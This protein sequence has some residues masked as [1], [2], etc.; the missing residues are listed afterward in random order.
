MRKKKWIQKSVALLMVS[1]MIASVGCGKSGEEDKAQKKEE[2][3]TED[4]KDI[5]TIG[6]RQDSTVLDFDTN[7][8]TEQLEKAAN[9]EL[10]FFFFPADANEFKQKLS[11][12]IS[13]E[14]ELP[15]VI[16]TD[17]MLGVEEIQLYGSDGIFLP[18]DEYY[19]DPEKM[20]VFF[21]NVP[22]EDRELMI[23]TCQSLDGNLYALPQYTPEIGNEYSVRAWINKTWL[24]NLNLEMPKTTDDFYNVLKAFKEQDPNGNGKND[25]IPMMGSANGWN[26]NPIPFI[27]N[28]FVYTDPVSTISKYMYLNENGEVVPSFTDEGW[29]KG[30]EFINKLVEEDLLSELSFT[31]DVNQFKTV[32]ENEEDQLMGCF[33]AGS[34]SAYT[35]GS[36]NSFDMDVL[37]PLTGPDGECNATYRPWL[38]LP[39]GHITKNCDNVDAAMRFI[40]ACYDRDMSI[41]ARA[42][43][44]EVDWTTDVGDAKS[45]YEESLGIK[46]GYVEI[47]TIWGTE[48]NSHWNGKILTYLGATDPYSIQGKGVAADTPSSSPSIMTPK[49]IPYY[50]DKHPEEIIVSLPYEDNEI[51]EMSDLKAVIEPYV[52]QCMT[53]FAT[54]V[55]P[56]SEW[57]TYLETL[58]QMGLERYIEL[59][60]T[61]YER[62]K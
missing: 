61:A 18:L 45:P 35:S 60:Q 47:N 13:G 23:K 57:D 3:V 11:L 20:P 19:S 2:S 39:S 41:V 25:E 51:Q 24:D 52:E 50:M 42:G 22:E 1:S 26:Q 58:D 10:K 48:Q 9:V 46:T 12:M 40:D 30:L 56:F 28:A 32:L 34:M 16:F 29:K 17:N 6:V 38:P 37:P 55:L 53:Q 62:T 14:S 7:Y 49:A 8:L 44:P 33:A 31:Q 54:G 27:M 15:D 59:M 4:G 36:K 21:E 43:V 5:L